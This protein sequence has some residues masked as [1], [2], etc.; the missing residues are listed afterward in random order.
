MK[1]I[2]INENGN[3]YYCGC[4]RKTWQSHDITEFDSDEDCKTHIK[5][6]NELPS[7]D[8]D[9]TITEAYQMFGDGLQVY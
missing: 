9:S 8:H 7:T 1:Y 4:C 3:G 5:T 6:H 2:L